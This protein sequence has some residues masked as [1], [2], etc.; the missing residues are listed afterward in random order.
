MHLVEGRA[1]LD[2]WHGRK[3]SLGIHLEVSSA[4]T[5]QVAHDDQQIGRRLYWQEPAPRHVYAC[6]AMNN[7]DLS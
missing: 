5:V 3:R 6:Q 1:Q 2:K 7:T 4:E